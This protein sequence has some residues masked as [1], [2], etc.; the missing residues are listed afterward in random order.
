MATS[1]I[2]RLIVSSMFFGSFLLIATPSLAGFKYTS[3]NGNLTIQFK[4]SEINLQIRIRKTWNLPSI[5]YLSNIL[6]SLQ[7][8]RLQPYRPVSLG[9]QIAVYQ[10]MLARLPHQPDALKHRLEV[11]E[12][13]S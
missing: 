7:L 5:S 4:Y 6:K 3:K 12:L 11:V 1:W 9:S 2:K 10:D 8:R 13:S